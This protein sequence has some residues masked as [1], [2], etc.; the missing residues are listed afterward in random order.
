MI[1]ESPTTTYKISILN[2]FKR[3]GRLDSLN[4]WNKKQ[5][6]ADDSLKINGLWYD[7]PSSRIANSVPYDSLGN[8]ILKWKSLSGL[9][10]FDIS[11]AYKVT[12]RWDMNKVFVDTFTLKNRTNTLQEGELAYN[13]TLGDSWVI[14][15][16]GLGQKDSLE[17]I[18]RIRNENRTVFGAWTFKGGGKEVLIDNDRLRFGAG[19]SFVLPTGSSQDYGGEL[20]YQNYRVKYWDDNAGAY[21]TLANLSD[22]TLTLAT[23]YWVNSNFPK[24]SATNNWTGLNTFNANTT[25]NSA[26]F[27][28]SINYINRITSES[29]SNLGSDFIFSEITPSTS[30]SGVD[31]TGYK[32]DITSSGTPTANIHYGVYSTVGGYPSGGSKSYGIYGY[33]YGANTSYGIYGKGGTY[34]GYFD[35]N[36]SIIGSLGSTGERVTKGWFTDLEV[37]NTI[38][39]SISGN[40]A[41]ATNIYGGSANMLPYQSGANTTS[42]I[43]APSSNFMV[44]NY[45]SGFAWLSYTSEATPATIVSRN[46]NGY[47]YFARGYATQYFE[48]PYMKVTN[49]SAM[50]HLYFSGSAI[51]AYLKPPISIPQN[52]EYEIYLPSGN[53]TLVLQSTNINTSGSLTGGGNLSTD[54]TLSLVN[55]N[56]SPGNSKY[57]GTN[58]SGT[59]GFF[60]LP[61]GGSGTVTSVAMTVPTG[62]Q[63][64][65]SPI[66]TSGTLALTFASGYSLPTDA[67]QSNWS[68]AYSWGNHASAGYAT[69]SN[70]MTFTN[71]TWNGS[72]IGIGY[73]GTNN[74]SFTSQKLIYYDGSKLA[75]T[76]LD[77]GS[78]YPSGLFD[79]TYGEL[80]DDTHS[81]TITTNDSSYVKWTGSTIGTCANIAGNTT[82]DNLT[83]NSG[84]GGIFIITYTVTFSVS[85]AGDYYWTVNV[86][87]SA[88]SKLRTIIT[89]TTSTHYTT[90]CTAIVSLSSGNTVDLGCYSASGR[91][92]YVTYA[93]L[94]IRKI[95]N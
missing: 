63:I 6:F 36:V 25:F 83:V 79:P 2:L 75:S 40:A 93:N 3:L 91:T 90:T 60:D 59:K 43:S 31:I 67:N 77:A 68:T 27:Q 46:S 76:N 19:S 70:T 12:G 20:V 69:A 10:E 82:N 47:S 14:F 71:K 1:I 41:T 61:S 85:T 52:T 26:T 87:G 37:T 58:A 39:G 74:N 35:G 80:Y 92:V 57:Y 50:G 51:G 56:A 72:T 30:T 66:T 4:T 53:G 29:H 32:V 34:A 7:F 65:G 21:R 94:N 18:R 13:T 24:L 22:T 55:D 8:G 23:R 48:A 15:G 17:S 86:N 64:S 73:G 49:G 28:K 9:A 42:F 44:L 5:I 16:Y 62:F 45:N 38:T 84:Y 54:R 95:S 11:K 88:V 78:F 81:S 89:A 33:A